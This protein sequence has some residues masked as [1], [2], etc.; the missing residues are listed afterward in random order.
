MYELYL[1]MIDKV[2]EV[3]TIPVIPRINQSVQ[4]WLR[5]CGR[6]HLRKY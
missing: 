6:I 2:F 1:V 4:R 5:F 3:E